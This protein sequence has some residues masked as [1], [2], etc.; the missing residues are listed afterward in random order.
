M[1]WQRSQVARSDDLVC[2]SSCDGPRAPTAHLMS[3]IIPF[4]TVPTSTRCPF[5]S[6]WAPMI[7]AARLPQTPNHLPHSRPEHRGGR[8]DARGSSDDVEVDS[9][10][11]RPS[12]GRNGGNLACRAPIRLLFVQPAIR[13]AVFIGSSIHPDRPRL[14]EGGDWCSFSGED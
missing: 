7:P 4:P 10:S 9:R 14:A 11:D 8:G 12:G 2:R 13:G 3:N 6:Q 1:T 5:H